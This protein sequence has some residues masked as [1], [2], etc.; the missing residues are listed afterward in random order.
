MHNIGLIPDT[1]QFNE[2][3]NDHLLHTFQKLFS[4]DSKLY[5]SI[6]QILQNGREASLEMTRHA[7]QIGETNI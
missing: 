3:H 6:Y 7:F 2:I 4:E 1:T 5:E